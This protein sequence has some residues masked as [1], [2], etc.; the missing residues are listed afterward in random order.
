MTYA[1][2]ERLA[3]CTLLSDLGPDQPTLCAGWETSDL[4]A[5]L[6]L[7]ERRPDAGVGILGGPL[8]RYTRAVQTRLARGTPF[9]KMV[10]LIRTGPPRMSPFG[11][12]GADE[13]LNLVEFFVHHEDIRRAQPGWEPREISA[14]L[15][16]QLWKRLG[17]A[18][19]VLRKAPVGV[20]LVRE[21]AGQASKRVRMTAKART[22]V[23]TV[24]GTPAEL[25]M[26]VLGRT[27][28]ARVRLDGSD[29][30]IAALTAAS[31]RL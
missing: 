1:R 12:P 10:S 20:E 31:W 14:D 9:P 27:R 26:W 3:L 30:D 29:A 11:L 15:S 24:T 5:H 22:P 2:D 8:A 6:I 21:D 17:V 4:A 7:R 25:T 13:R 16:E 23:V 19:M 28:E 18:K